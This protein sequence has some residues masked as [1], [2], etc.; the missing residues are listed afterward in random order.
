M[1]LVSHLSARCL[2]FF[3]A[4]G[5]TAECLSVIVSDMEE[6][7][8]L[9]SRPGPT[10]IVCPTSVVDS[11]ETEIYSRFAPAFR[12][13]FLVYY[14][15]AK[16]LSAEQL[17][18][19]DIVVTTFGSLLPAGLQLRSFKTDFDAA[20]AVKQSQHP[21]FAV[22]WRRVILDEA[23]YIR[24]HNSES[25]R[26][27]RLLNA[28]HRW[29]V[30][31]TPIQNGVNDLLSLFMFLQFRPVDTPKLF[32]AEFGGNQKRDWDT[33]QQKSAPVNIRKLH[34]VLSPVMLRRRKDSK[35]ADGTP[36]VQLPKKT[37]LVTEA[38]FSPEEAEFY[39]QL[40]TRMAARFKKFADEGLVYQNYT[41]VL[42]MIQKLRQACNHPHLATNGKVATPGYQEEGKSLLDSLD[43]AGITAV[44]EAPPEGTSSSIPA[45]IEEKLER[46]RDILNPPFEET[47]PICLDML[48]APASVVCLC[49]H[50]YCKDCITEW[51]D[52]D[53][54]SPCPE[55]RAPLDADPLTPLP[56]VQA[57]VN[58]KWP[59]PP[60]V[61]AEQKRI[62]AEKAAA[63]AAEAAA[64]A[65][66]APK[67][68]RKF[69]ASAKLI[70]LMEELKK[71][72]ANDSTMKCIVFSN[73][74]SFLDLCMTTMKHSGDGF[75]AV[76]VDGSMDMKSRQKQLQ[77]FRT[78]SRVSVLVM[79]LKAGS[80]GLNLTSA[81]NVVLCEPWWNP[82]P[83]QQAMDRVHRTGQ[84][85]PVTVIKLT[86]D[87][88][89][90][91]RILEMQASKWQVAD[92]VLGEDSGMSGDGG[93]KARKLSIQEL[94]SLF[95]MK[96]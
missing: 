83:E 56:N 67:V 24:N 43:A 46:L 3:G 91:Q 18:D 4:Q 52:A 82:M 55:C 92:S 16:L 96:R 19:L 34:A 89:I 33:G 9:S 85:K 40:E 5:K 94:F 37:I 15:D 6:Q 31:G 58:E 70:K 20:K 21:L 1:S 72:K 79:S 7:K 28:E 13:A 51:R 64:A 30:T 60:K 23:H 78:D 86:V 54:N 39:T 22:K 95:G 35:K 17:Q 90:E 93:K 65:A 71:M 32:H 27:C 62:K 59:P 87:G 44:P 42:V 57:R 36:I 76:R 41:N 11:W 77:I 69:L 84:Q 53:G 49:G 80:H 45:P 26:A 73:F 38:N 10:L 88:T 74:T 12:P 48:D 81:N 8:Q 25:A 2:S 29:A 50:L 61:K 68:K 66:G 47:C 14:G 63:E 75:R